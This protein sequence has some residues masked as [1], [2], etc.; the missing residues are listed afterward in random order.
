MKFEVISSLG[1][2]VFSTEYPECV[3]SDDDLKHLWNCGYKFQIDKKN[4]TLKKLKAFLSKY[5]HC[6]VTDE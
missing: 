1:A 6:D 3:P 5:D 4:Y 2:P